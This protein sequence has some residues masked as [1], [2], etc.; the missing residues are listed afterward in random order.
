MRKI[1]TVAI[2]GG[3]VSGLSAGGLLARKGWKVKLFEA[4]GKLGGSCANTNLGGTLFTMVLCIWHSLG[5]W[6]R[7]LR[8]W[9]LTALRSCPYGK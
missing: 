8:D 1:N 5:F 2:I 7:Y 3:G 6:S 4:N 9:G